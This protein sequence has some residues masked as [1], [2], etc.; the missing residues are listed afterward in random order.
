M[1][2]EAGPSPNGAPGEERIR[3][4]RGEAPRPA[5][6]VPEEEFDE[7]IR[8]VRRNRPPREEDLTHLRLLSIFYYVVGGFALLCYSF[9]VI[10]LIMGIGMVTG[11][12]PGTPPPAPA[13]SGRPPPAAAPPT[14]VGWM[15]VIFSTVAIAFGWAFAGGLFTTGWLLSKRRGHV[16]CLVMAGIACLFQPL[17][18]VLGIFTF[19]VLL[20]PS[21]KELFARG[22]TA[23]PAK[24]VTSDD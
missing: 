13:G 3:E 17:V 12:F 16:F 20:R 4:V 5:P 19:I 7:D 10:Y 22:P 8:E 15:F 18:M 1:P 11:S 21:V 2:D 6:P 14:A 9:P 23:V 24:N